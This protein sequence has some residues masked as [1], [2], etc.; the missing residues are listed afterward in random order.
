[1]GTGT[2]APHE[3]CEVRLVLAGSKPL[4]AIEM[5]KDHS[6]YALA[7][8]MASTGALILHQ[9][10]GEV[11]IVKPNNREL[12]GEYIFLLENGIAEYGSIEYTRRM[13]RMF[14]YTEAD[15]EAF[16]KEDISC[17]CDKCTGK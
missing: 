3:N 8:C 7:R 13:G 10:E 12:L 16:I 15:V 9:L 2:V 4:A 1:M 5:E 6:S 11:I 17:D 14:G